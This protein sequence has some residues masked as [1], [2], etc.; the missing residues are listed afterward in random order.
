M[1]LRWRNPVSLVLSSA[2]WCAA[3]YVSSYLVLGTMWFA[4]SVV[5]VLLGAGLSLT[6][7]GLPLLL[8]A[9][10]ATQLMAGIE[11]R[12]AGAVLGWSSGAPR[13]TAAR[14]AAGIGVRGR[15]R[16]RLRDG[17]TWQ[18]LVVLV[19]LYPA[20]LLVDLVGLICWLM[21]W[22][23]ISLPFWYRYPPQTFDNGTSGH[24]VELGYYPDG[25]TGT[26][27][28]GWFIDDAHSALIAAGVGVVLV[29][30]VGNYVVVGSA[31]LHA[32]VV[33]SRLSR[34]G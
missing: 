9:L 5:L 10:V 18:G 28:Y 14:A 1:R 12:R 33:L 34:H 15:L 23:L 29:L 13:R 16:S 19:A 26:R 6:W 25:P 4:V 31:R 3:G 2:P 24:G 27:R 7:V 20:M 32:R 22:T 17:A 11:R 21:P 8:A 30:L